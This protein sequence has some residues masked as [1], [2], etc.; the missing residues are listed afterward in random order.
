M[1]TLWPALW[2]KCCEDQGRKAK[3]RMRSPCEEP[4][5]SFGGGGQSLCLPSH[6]VF[7]LEKHF[8]YLAFLL[9]PHMIKLYAGLCQYHCLALWKFTSSTMEIV[10]KNE[11]YPIQTKIYKIKKKEVARMPGDRGGKGA[12]S[13]SCPAAFL[14]PPLGTMSSSPSHFPQLQHSRQTATVG[15][16]APAHI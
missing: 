9:T 16:S 12:V 3:Q 7:L 15:L 10:K 13:Y 6:L 1:T 2:A 8:Y 14:P 4:F 11:S 5:R